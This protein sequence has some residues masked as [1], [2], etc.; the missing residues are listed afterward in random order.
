MV[1]KANA[2]WIGWGSNPHTVNNFVW[3]RLDKGHGWISLHHKGKGMRLL[4]RVQS[5]D[6]GSFGRPVNWTVLCAGL[7]GNAGILLSINLNYS[8]RVVRFRIVHRRVNKRMALGYRPCVFL[9]TKSAR[10]P[11]RGPLVKPR[12]RKKLFTMN[13]FARHRGRFPIYLRSES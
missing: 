8:C 4:E 9:L 3:R 1:I 13:D 6:S 11:P 7:V 2:Y 5:Y 10:A 12:V